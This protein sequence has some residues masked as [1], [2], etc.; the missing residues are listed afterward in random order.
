MTRNKKAPSAA[1]HEGSGAGTVRIIGGQWR[2]RRVPIMAAPGLRPT[3]DRVRETLYNWLQGA[4]INARVLDLYAGTG[5]LGLEALSR[6]AQHATFVERDPRVAQRLR[7]TLALLGAN[8]AVVHTDDAAAFV[9]R[10]PPAGGS[11]DGVLMDPP[12]AAE[13]QGDLCKLL[14]RNQ[15]LAER[16]WIYLESPSEQG[17]PRLPAGW[18]VSRS[19]RAGAVMAT[20]VRRGAAGSADA[21]PA[22][23]GSIAKDEENL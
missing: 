10:S 21:T 9:A 3:P 4:L 22:P 14:E 6:G 16:A 1:V 5:A 8:N 18:R 23:D 7:D 15:W 2:G 11:Y 17:I 13:V 19:L 20:L 12:F